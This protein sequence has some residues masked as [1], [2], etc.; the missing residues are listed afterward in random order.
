VVEPGTLGILHEHHVRSQ[1]QH[2]G[3]PL[4]DLHSDSDRRDCLFS[5]G[6]GH[7][8]SP[9]QARS[10]GVVYGNAGLCHRIA[11]RQL[12]IARRYLNHC[13]Q[14]RLAAL[15]VFGMAG[16]T[17]RL[18]R[19]QGAN[20]DSQSGTFTWAAGDVKLPPGFT[21]QA[22]R[23]TDTSE[24]HFTSRDK[25]LIVRHDIGGYAG[26]WASRQRAF[27]FRE[28]SVGGFRVLTAKRHWP[29]GK[30]GQTVLVA[31]TFPDAG[32]AN[33]F[34][35]SSNPEDAIVIEYIARTFHGRGR[36]DP[37]SAVCSDKRS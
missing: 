2:D 1:L 20:W 4:H 22:D 6:V 11:V 14:A 28:A 16:C 23:G 12:R 13:M 34:L 35:E 18:P 17:H 8:A 36:P 31:V 9:V 30:G 3:M 27:S 25:R 24:G 29:D 37:P 33:F 32:C 7:L 5:R 19:P 10:F 21:Y 15:V 26:C